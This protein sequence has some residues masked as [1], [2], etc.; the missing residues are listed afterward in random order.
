MRIAQN[1]FFY[2][3]NRRVVPA[4]SAA[5]DLG[6]PRTALRWSGLRRLIRVNAQ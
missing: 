1:P 3:L 6:D 5:G 4:A 2:G